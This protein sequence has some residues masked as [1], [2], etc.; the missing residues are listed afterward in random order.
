MTLVVA[1]ISD[2]VPWFVAD[3]MIT[4]NH[5]SVRD[6]QYAVKI[7]PSSNLN[8]LFAYAGNAHTGAVS[9][10]KASI[11]KTLEEAR[12]I[13]VEASRVP[14]NAGPDDGTDFLLATLH[15]VPTISRI[16]KGSV[17]EVQRAHIGSHD[18][19]EQLQKIRHAGDPTVPDAIRTIL[20]G[21]VDYPS[22]P[23]E[24]VACIR[25]FYDLFASRDERDVGGWAI[26]YFLTPVGPKF[27]EYAQ[28]ISDPI[29][30]Q[31]SP[32][33]AVPL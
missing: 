31:L 17:R 7:E 14:F 10:Y 27:C 29:A 32:G 4:G 22:V 21:A 15:D 28:S 8:A 33:V 23:G 30:K 26:G 19:F 20:V 9:V 1:G 25:Q 6:R 13:L 16:A 24:Q 18:A 2:G 11:A 3:S 12:A 5:L